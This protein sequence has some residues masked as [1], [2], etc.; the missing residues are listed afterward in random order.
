MRFYRRQIIARGVA[1][2]LDRHFGPSGVYVE[3]GAGSSETT[4]RTN[5]GSR[6]FVAL[7]YSAFILKRTRYNPMIDACANG[8]IFRLPFG[9]GSLDGIWNVGVMEH[10]EHNDIDRI[11][12]EFGRV[13][14]TGGKIVLLW[15]M[16][17]APYEIFINIVESFCNRVLKK[18]F[19]FY[20]DEVSRLRSRRQGREI[21]ER[22]PF[23]LDSFHFNY[24]DA[25]SFGVIVATRPEALSNTSA[26]V[27]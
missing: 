12:Q 15:P 2:H 23:S 7:D 22:S 20:P 1:H 17:Y 9:D 18:P 4:I 13:V 27:V 24:R 26:G 16:A 5:K 14:K 19:Q 6:T 10:Y 21:I 8:D 25:F 11:L 3:C